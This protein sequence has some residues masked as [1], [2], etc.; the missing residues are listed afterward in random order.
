[1]PRQVDVAPMGFRVVRP[2]PET[3]STSAACAAGVGAMADGRAMSKHSPAVVSRT[4]LSETHLVPLGLLPSAFLRVASK[5]TPP[6]TS[7]PVSTPARPRPCFGEA[8]PRASLGPPSWV[9][10]TL[11]VCSTG[12][13]WACCIPLPTLGFTGFPPSARRARR[14]SEAFPPVHHPPELSPPPAAV[15]RVA[16]WPCPLAVASS[17]DGVG[18]EAFIRWGVRCVNPP[19]PT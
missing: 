9:L 4:P 14:G 2:F 8:L 10:T 6:S 7:P 18:F 5:T 17:E 12:G 15:P 19:L 3:S 16:A 11:T 1:M 13:S